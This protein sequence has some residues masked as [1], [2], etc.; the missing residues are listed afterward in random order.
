MAQKRSIGESI[1]P[2]RVIGFF[3]AGC[4]VYLAR[5]EPGQPVE[6]LLWI[7]AFFVTLYPHL[8]YIVYSSRSSSRNAELDSLLADMFLLGWI[9]QLV[10]FQP[11]IALC[12]VIA[13]SATSY[14]VGGVKQL[15]RGLAA[16][17]L[18]LLT[19]TLLLGFH[20]QPETRL[21]ELLPAF[22]YLA[23]ATHYIG[24]LSYVRGKAIL[25]SM[26]EA[27]DLAHRDGLT[28]IANRRSFDTALLD[29]WQRC[30]RQGAPLSLVLL[31]I[32]HFKAY[33]D[34]YGHPAG[35]ECLR[36][37]AARIADAV[38]H[39]GD[40]AARFGGEEFGILLPGADGAGA[41]LVAQRVHEGVRELTIPHEAS[42]VA[43]V[44]TVSV[45]VASVVPTSSFTSRGLLLAADQALYAAKE[46]GRDRIVAHDA[47]ARSILTTSERGVAE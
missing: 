33:N 45:G 22:I 5:V 24:F 27:E 26:Q 8:A 4:S 39:P 29:E 44:V 15:A 14:S 10:H 19:V 1:Y 11:A 21:V 47:S 38:S 3:L 43:T 17:G 23:L 20:F 41:Q 12:Y 30:L 31:D 36:R 25:H 28:Q 40:L 35:D 42:S 18:G 16:L 7:V 46:T 6:P 34:R 13:N 2:M 9:A 32:D 37:V